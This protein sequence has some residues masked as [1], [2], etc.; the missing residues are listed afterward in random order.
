ME[1]PIIFSSAGRRHV[2]SSRA[3]FAV[4]AVKGGAESRALFAVCAVKGGA[5]SRALFAVCAV[6]GG[7]GRRVPRRRHE[8]EGRRLGLREML[9]I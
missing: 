2:T 5:E 8:E 4:C 6:K 1:C 3:L 9:H 7:A